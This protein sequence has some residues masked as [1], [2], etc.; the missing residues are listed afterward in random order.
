MPRRIDLA[1]NEVLE[2][3]AGIENSLFDQTKAT[4]SKNWLLQRGTERGLEIISEAVRHVPDEVLATQPQIAWSDIRS[5]GNIIRHEYH[6]VDPD[7][8]WAVVI[9]DLPDL[10]QA[11]QNL[12]NHLGE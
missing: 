5:I 12:L 4:F 6:R 3:I 11:V 7:V 1:L 9:D 10:K 8:I 2:A